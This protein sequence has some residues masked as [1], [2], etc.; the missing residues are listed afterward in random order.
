[1]GTTEGFRGVSGCDEVSASQEF[2]WPLGRL[3]QDEGRQLKE[4]AAT[5]F[6]ERSERQE[7]L[8]EGSASRDLC[9]QLSACAAAP[10]RLEQTDTWHGV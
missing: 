5:V 1:M 6:Q 10:Y 3:G 9:T 4:E 7:R 2:L 8:T